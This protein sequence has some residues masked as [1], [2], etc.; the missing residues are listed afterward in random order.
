MDKIWPTLYSK[1]S[2]GE[3]RVWD[4]SVQDNNVSVSHGIKGGK[5]VTKVTQSFGKNK[6]KTNA[7]TDHTQALADAQSKWEK[8]LKRGYYNTEEEAINSIDMTP[9]KLQN[10]ADQEKKIEYPCY[11]QTKLDGL[12]LLVDPQMKAQSKAG[13]D[14]IIPSHILED[15]KKLKDALKDHWHGLD[16]EVYAGHKERGGLSLQE[17]VSAF[18]K[19]NENT[20]RLQYWVYDIPKAGEY[21]STRNERLEEI[22]YL[23][24]SLNIK[25][26]VILP[27]KLVVSKS[28]IDLMFKEAAKNKEEGLVVRNQRGYYEFG[29]RSYDAQKMKHRSTTEAYVFSA[30]QDKNGESVLT[31]SL[32]D[33]TMFKVKMRKDA[34]PDINLRLWENREHI[35]D[36]FIEVEYEDMSDEGVPLKPVGLRVREVDRETWEPKE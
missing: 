31:A 23:V 34:D 5:I 7:T 35:L 10:F 1:G 8:Q 21:F 11:V 32:K 15:I 26:I 3:I 19:E 2:K 33:N 24:E 28:Q 16:G 14:Y 17:I 20:P 25:N 36:K 29:K 18:R 6:G 22:R 27:S 12:R 30:T 4:I 9:M 13:E